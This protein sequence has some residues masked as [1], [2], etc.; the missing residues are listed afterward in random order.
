M[1]IP[2]GNA[3]VGQS[4]GP[5]SAINATLSGVVRGVL[6]AAAKGKI[7]TLY[8]MKN[9]VEG[10]LQEQLIDLSSFFCGRYAT[11]KLLEQTPAAAL[12]SCRR[13]LPEPLSDP[14]VYERMLRIFRQYEIRFFFYIGG[15]DS[16]DTVAK[17]SAFLR[18][19]D[20]EM[21]V[22]GIPK[23]IDND[24]VGTDHTPGFGSAAK[25]VA[26]TTR[27]ILTDCAAYTTP[28]VTII[29]TMGRDSGWLTAASALG[30]MAGGPEPD[31]VYLPER[32]FC[33]DR[34]LSDVRN[35]L[36]RHPNVVVVASE[37]IRF[38]D[39]RYV[40][41]SRQRGASDGFGH[42]RLAGTGMV[43]ENEVRKKIGCKVRSI[44]LNLPQ[45]CGAHLA[46]ATDLSE[47]RKA[48]RTAV[49]FALRGLSGEVVV[50][51]RIS[52]DPYRIG[53]GHLPAGQIA[54]RIRPVDDRFID[55]AGNHVTNAC[56][57]YLLPLI[58]GEVRQTYQNGM[59]EY[60]VFTT[61][62]ECREKGID[63]NKRSIDFPMENQP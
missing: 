48:G 50:L 62:S 43:L 16:M 51:R 46:S 24:M 56:C 2:F 31:L 42:S 17:L 53:F 28:A 6:E 45:R 23:T 4:G 26:V 58:R 47:A 36:R 35:A 61:S 54:N 34:F 21:A 41:A 29:E 40:G 27:E 37:G 20:Y 13:K 39:G 5:T 57:E 12:G 22:I 9:G 7:G 8:G 10:L 19:S 3:V 33:V 59:P 11:L 18:R 63:F 52:S 30:R 1:K 14:A 38:R 55:P 49:R 60:C 44:E 15:N 25:Y 32:P